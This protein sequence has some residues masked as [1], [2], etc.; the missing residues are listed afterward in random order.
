V[1]SLVDGYLTILEGMLGAKSSKLDQAFNL[2]PLDQ[3]SVCVAEV[4][5]ML[6]VHIP[7][8]KIGNSR[9]DLHEAGKLG[10]DS[11]LAAQTFGWNPNWDTQQVIEKTAAWYKEFLSRKSSALDICV[12]QLDSWSG[13][14]TTT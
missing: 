7:G 5:S 8:V 6:S 2:G 13:I 3:S 1:I 4:L 9:T 12:Q 10:L 14:K 11:S